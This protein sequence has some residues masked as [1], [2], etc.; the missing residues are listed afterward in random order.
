MIALFR[1]IR[2]VLRRYERTSGPA[3]GDL[4]GGGR[5]HETMTETTRMR[6]RIRAVFGVGARAPL[7]V[8]DRESLLQYHQYLASRLVFPFRASYFDGHE[9]AIWD[10][11]TVTRLIDPAECSLDPWS[12]L[13]CEVFACGGPVR[14]RLDE[15]RVDDGSANQQLID[16]YRHWFDARR[17]SPYGS[18]LAA[19]PLPRPA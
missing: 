18:C 3:T 14:I 13:Q 2:K 10:L 1:D 8:V 11:V 19:G 16:D 7:P 15:L 6:A 9:G 12:G 17:T 5:R 4:G